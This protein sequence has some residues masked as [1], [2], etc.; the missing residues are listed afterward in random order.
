[1]TEFPRAAPSPA[2]P[3]SSRRERRPVVSHLRRRG[4]PLL[5]SL[6][7]PLP[8]IPLSWSRGA[9]GEDLRSKLLPSRAPDPLFVSPRDFDSFLGLAILLLPSHPMPH[10]LFPSCCS[11]DTRPP[12]PSPQTPPSPSSTYPQPLPSS[13]FSTPLFLPHRYYFFSSPVIYFHSYF[14]PPFLFLLFPVSSPPSLAF[15]ALCLCSPSST[16]PQSEQQG[17]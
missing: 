5:T 10:R 11:Q 7:S 6:R 8:S 16:A 17:R 14:S 12:S 9:R 1:M 3:R 2:R 13:P 15:H 4:S